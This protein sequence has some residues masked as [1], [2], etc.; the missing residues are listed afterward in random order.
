MMPS[1]MGQL[2]LRLGLQLTIAVTVNSTTKTK[3]IFFIV[4][5]WS[6]KL[7]IAFV[8]FAKIIYEA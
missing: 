6:L 3:N 4:F 5:L 8:L 2:D 1:V 7:I